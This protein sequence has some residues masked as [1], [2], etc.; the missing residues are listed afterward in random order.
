M[1]PTCGIRTSEKLVNVLSSGPG[2]TKMS[3][4][5]A[6]SLKRLES[7]MK[8][9][10]TLLV[11]LTQLLLLFAT[12]AH[13]STVAARDGNIVFV[14][15]AGS[16]R[17][18]TRGGMDSSPALSPDGKQVAFVRRTPGRTTETADEIWVVG[19]DAK[20]A[21]RLVEAREHQDPKQTLAA[22]KSPAFS[23]DG[24]WIY[25]LSSAWATSDAVHAIGIDGLKERFIADGNS[26]DVVRAGQYQGA[27]IVRKHEYFLG[28]GSYDW[29]WLLSA[30]GQ[31]I[32]PVGPD[33][34]N[35]STFK[36]AL[37]R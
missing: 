32:G 5:A 3:R 36:N 26:L 24:R 10:S 20:R 8:L 23:P 18:L 9:L 7:F 19:T 25:F 11:I 35:V 1:Q 29:Y 21:R 13:G 31:E 28:G 4:R 15:D 6:L 2:A 34:E 27:L 14:D 17:Q 16:A 33:E 30:S 22:L 12:D 37:P